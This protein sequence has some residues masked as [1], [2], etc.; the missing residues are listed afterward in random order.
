MNA[1]A[2]ST[3][4]S[5]GR[6]CTITLQCNGTCSFWL[7]AE[8]QRT[9]FT[10]VVW[11]V[12]CE[13]TL[14]CLGLLPAL[15][16]GFRSLCLQLGWLALAFTT[17]CVGP[18]HRLKLVNVFSLE[19]YSS[20]SWGVTLTVSSAKQIW[21]CTSNVVWFNMYVYMY[22][23]LRIWKPFAFNIQVPKVS[24][25]VKY[26]CSQVPFLLS[27]GRIKNVRCDFF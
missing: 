25:P 26:M 9:A 7:F 1:A 12:S 15:N 21:S 22:I 8:H 23:L 24:Y 20:K 4:H 17:L 14:L 3:V 16:F 27:H 18:T 13:C 6:E 2:E 10:A 11:L 19:C 5:W